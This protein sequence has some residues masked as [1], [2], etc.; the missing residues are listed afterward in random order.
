M[1]TLTL[2][3]LE[4]LRRDGLDDAKIDGLTAL[5]PVAVHQGEGVIP[6]DHAAPSGEK[7]VEK[8]PLA[9]VQSG[10]L[11]EPRTRSE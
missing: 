2:S 4:V 10:G 3:A 7:Y 1:I 5:R 11:R 9:A 6:R 8:R